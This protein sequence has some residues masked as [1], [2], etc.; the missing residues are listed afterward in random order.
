MADIEIVEFRAYVKNTLQG[1]LTVRVPSG[2]EIRDITL[3][4]K[5]GKR[6]I[7]MPAKSYK[8]ED[9]TEAWVLIVRLPDQHRWEAFQNAV[10]RAMNDYRPTKKETPKEED[11]PF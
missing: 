4:E 5:N 6:W 7:S 8:K 10:L 3:H 9:G 11:I 1:F 2:W